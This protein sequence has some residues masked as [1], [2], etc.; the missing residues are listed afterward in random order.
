M[1]SCWQPQPSPLASTQL[2]IEESHEE[3][4]MVLSRLCTNAS[5]IV[6]SYCA[7][8]KASATCCM[9]VCRRCSTDQDSLAF[10]VASEHHHHRQCPPDRRRRHSALLACDLGSARRRWAARCG[11]G[12]LASG[13]GHRN[14]GAATEAVL[15]G[16]S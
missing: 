10:E 5:P 15:L 11:R 9:I 4:T 7:S 6:P 2:Q 1:A 14:E 8:Y 16:R 13:A 3:S 12:N